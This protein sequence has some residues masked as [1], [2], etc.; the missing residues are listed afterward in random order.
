MSSQPNGSSNHLPQQEVDA[1]FEHSFRS[2]IG[3]EHH[4]VRL[5]LDRTWAE[6]IKPQQLMESQVITENPDGSI[7]LET[8]VNSLDEVASWVVSRGAGVTVPGA[9]TPEGKGA[10]PGAGRTGELLP[11]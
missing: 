6:R 10:C 9:G 7:V 4:T 3:T 11:R 5:R 8:T 2:W 1:L